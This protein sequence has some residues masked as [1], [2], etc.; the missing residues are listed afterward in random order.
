MIKGEFCCGIV[1]K[2]EGVGGRWKANSSQHTSSEPLYNSFA[3]V[4]EE[5]KV[6]VDGLSARLTHS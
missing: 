4:F 5:L 6:V 1:G 2:R 3:I